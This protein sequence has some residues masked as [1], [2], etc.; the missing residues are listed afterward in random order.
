MVNDLDYKGITFPV[1]KKDYKKIVQKNSICIN[2][3]C[4]ENGLTYPMYIS[5]Q[6]F[7]DYMDLLL[8]NDENKSHY[9]CIKDFDKFMFNKTK[10][11]NKKHF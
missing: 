8:I 4:Y 1:S 7:E 3:F 5:K 2:V 6:K 9:V 10:H 11:K